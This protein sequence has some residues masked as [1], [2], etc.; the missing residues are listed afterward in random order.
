MKKI[1]MK[2][3]IPLPPLIIITPKKPL[4]PLN[5]I[6]LK[7][8]QPLHMMTMQIKIKKISKPLP[9]LQIIIMMKKKIILL[10]Q[11]RSQRIMNMV[12]R[13]MSIIHI[14]KETQKPLQNIITTME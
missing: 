5:T 9:P 8:K 2:K 12:L 10:T 3:P 1:H 14:Q 6:T 7:K 13:A 11:L 4:P